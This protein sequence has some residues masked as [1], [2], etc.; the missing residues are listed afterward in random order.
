MTDVAYDR[1]DQLKQVQPFIMQGE[2]LYAV[3][4]CKGAATG[5]VAITDRRLIFYDKVFLRKRK[6][7]TSVPF[8][9]ITSV[10]CVDGGRGFLQLSANS[11]LVVK[12]AGGDEFEFDFR[13]GDKAQRAYGL[14]MQ[15]ILQ[16]EPV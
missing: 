16:N 10:S 5:F 11:E 1:E 8:N 3:F 2:Q 12:S 14:I 7:M 6:A 4:D 13:G 15:E 9:K